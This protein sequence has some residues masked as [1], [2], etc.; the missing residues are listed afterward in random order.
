MTRRRAT[1]AGSWYSGSRSQLGEFLVVIV[2][3]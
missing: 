2:T 3:S 1:H